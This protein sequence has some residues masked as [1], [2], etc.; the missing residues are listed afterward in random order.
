MS[1]TRLLISPYLLCGD[2][3]N[4]LKEQIKKLN[5]TVTTNSFP[6]TPILGTK[7]GVKRKEGTDKERMENQKPKQPIV[8]SIRSIS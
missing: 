2:D 7:T 3:G 8:I 5:K 6:N 1:V 4:Y